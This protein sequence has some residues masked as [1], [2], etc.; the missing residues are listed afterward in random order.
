MPL[1]FDELYDAFN[2][3]GRAVLVEPTLST[4]WHATIEQAEH[5]VLIYPNNK[6]S[7]IAHESATLETKSNG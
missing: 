7:R 6:L 5:L 1:W 4:R 2:Q 3:Q